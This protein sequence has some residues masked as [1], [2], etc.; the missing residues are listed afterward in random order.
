MIHYALRCI[1]GHAF[2]GW[3]RSSADFDAQQS[4]GLVACPH[5]GTAS[6]EK[7]L[8]APA[9]KVSQEK[10]RAP[11]SGTENQPPAQS[12]GLVPEGPQAQMMR[13][14][15]EMVRQ[16][17]TEATD[18]GDRFAEEARRIHYGEAEERKIYGSARTEDVKALLEDGVP[19]LPIPDLPE[20]QN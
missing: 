14:M 16:I 1:D 2:D 3:F 5:C 13:Q 8:M 17:K 6:V 9:I 12:V 11:A 15:A 20:E 19:V 10:G 18:V 7:M 4:R